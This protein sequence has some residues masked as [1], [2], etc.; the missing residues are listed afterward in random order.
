MTIA[1]IWVSFVKI[2]FWNS[3]IRSY[4]NIGPPIN[5][6]NSIFNRF[7]LEFRQK[8]AIK[9]QFGGYASPTVVKMLQENPALIKEGIKKEVSICF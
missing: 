5:S 1:M 7:V 9:K 4:D 3:M 2:F 8:Q 6:T